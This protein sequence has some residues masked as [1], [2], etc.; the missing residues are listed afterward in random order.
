MPVS[1]AS[2]ILPLFRPRD[3]SCM[4]GHGV[5]LDDYSFMSDDQGNGDFADHASARTVYAR[6]AGT[7]QPRMPVGGPFW[8]PDQLSKFSSW[9]DDGFQP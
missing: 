3:I 9:M 4:A 2:D 5:M 6:L 8:T 1:F 7:A